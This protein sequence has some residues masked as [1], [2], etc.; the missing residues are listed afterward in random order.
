ML[1]KEIH[2]AATDPLVSSTHSTRLMT[3][4]P[5]SNDKPLP[6]VNQCYGK[7]NPPQLNYRHE[8]AANYFHAIA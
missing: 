2:I 4:T 8:N 5:K 3:V 7:G 6:V 1:Q